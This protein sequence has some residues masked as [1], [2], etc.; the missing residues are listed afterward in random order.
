MLRSIRM[1]ALVSA[2]GLTVLAAA[3]ASGTVSG[4]VSSGGASGPGNVPKMGG[5]GY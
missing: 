4:G 2:L 1:L 3:C 5:G